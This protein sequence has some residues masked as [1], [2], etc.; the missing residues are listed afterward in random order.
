MPLPPK[1]THW[2]IFPGVGKL[3][4][5]GPQVSESGLA[6]A[7][8][9]NAGMF[10]IEKSQCE[11]RAWLDILQALTSRYDITAWGEDPP[12]ALEYLWSDL[13]SAYYVIM[14]IGPH[15]ADRNEQA[16]VPFAWIKSVRRDLAAINDP[17]D[18]G[19][20]LLASAGTVLR[21]RTGIQTPYLA[22]RDVTLFPAMDNETT[23]DGLQI[24]GSIESFQKLH[25]YISQTSLLSGLPGGF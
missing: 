9:G 12:P 10:Q 13:A 22:S 17:D 2:S 8:P 19:I 15:G 6:G 23:A 24:G 1:P 4:N 25:G 5:V 18:E 21:P 7:Q 3:K 20:T 16:M 14:W 11:M